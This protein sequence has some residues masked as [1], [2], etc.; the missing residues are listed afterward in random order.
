MKTFKFF[1]AAAM[2]AVS[3]VGC[4]D[5]QNASSDYP[6]TVRMDEAYDNKQ[7]TPLSSLASSVEYVRLETTDDALI[8]RINYMVA[9]E[10]YYFI[11]TRD[12]LFMFAAD[13]KF[14]RKIGSRGNGPGEYNGLNYFTADETNRLV[15][16]NSGSKIFIYNF[17]GVYQKDFNVE[18]GSDGNQPWQIGLLNHDIIVTNIWNITGQAENTLVLYDSDGNVTGRF[19]QYDRY[20]GGK[21]VS[22]ITNE[23]YLFDFDGNLYYKE[24]YNDTVFHVTT[25]ALSP[26]YIINLGKY[27]LPLES[28]L[29]TGASNWGEVGAYTLNEKVFETDNYLVLPYT[30]V[31][32]SDYI[33]PGVCVYEK[34]TG[35]GYN[36]DGGKFPNDVAGFLPFSPTNSAGDNILI[37]SWQSVDILD[38]AE[39]HPEAKEYWSTLTPEDNPVMMIVR[40]K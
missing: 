6:V 32:K 22:M 18:I 16:I 35:K 1:F 27:R 11:S 23:R 17:D 33:T 25:T 2:T 39:E 3:L 40:M 5:K 15:Y 20:D 38:Y 28:R 8:S 7:N 26:R 10:N 4:S 34:A 31:A 14:V 29:E 36:V 9:T 21:A 13:G 37:E 12:G 30:S 19:P 24:R